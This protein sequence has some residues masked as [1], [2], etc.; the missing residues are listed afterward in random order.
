MTARIRQIAVRIAEVTLREGTDRDGAIFNEGNLRGITNSDK[1]WWPQ[2]EAVVG[3]LNAAEISRRTEFAEAALR[4]WD[5]IEAKLID[6]QHGE[7]LRGVDRAGVPLA[8][9]FKVSFWK[10]PYHNGRTGLEAVRRLDAMI[11]CGTV[12]ENYFNE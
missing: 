7:W 11:V 5:F 4:T 2:A 3:W 10:C 9:Q 1:E 12:A 6:R 8:Q